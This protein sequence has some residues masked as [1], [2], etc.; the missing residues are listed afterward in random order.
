MQHLLCWNNLIS[1]CRLYSLQD[2][3]TAEDLASADHHEHI[4][5]LLGKL[6]KVKKNL[7]HFKKEKLFKYCFKCL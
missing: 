5:D 4:V 2:G 7:Q 3:K 6:K 1:P